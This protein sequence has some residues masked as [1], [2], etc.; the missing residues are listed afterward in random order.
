MESESA[1]TWFII[2]LGLAIIAAIAIGAYAISESRRY[3]RVPKT[4]RYPCDPATVSSAALSLIRDL[5]REEGQTFI[6]VT[7]DPLVAEKTRH[8]LTMKDGRLEAAAP[9]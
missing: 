2:F 6:I 4:R 9:V 3:S 5:N 1:P 7:H 8:I